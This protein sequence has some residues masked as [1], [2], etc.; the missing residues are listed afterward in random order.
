MRC[1]EVANPSFTCSKYTPVYS[2]SVGILRFTLEHPVPK[3]GLWSPP[4][5]VYQLVSEG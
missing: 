5:E 1:C 2:L 3:E 4:N